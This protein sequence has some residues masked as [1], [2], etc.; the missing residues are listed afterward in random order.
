MEQFRTKPFVQKLLGMGDID[1]LIRKVEELNLDNNE[2]LINK[3]KHGEFT[4]RDMYEQFQNIMKMG[5][6][7]QLM[8]MIPGFSQD[9]M[10]KG[11]EQESSARLKRLL[12]IMDSM[13]DGELDNDNVKKTFERQP[14]RI[15]R[16]AQGAGVM[17]WEVHELLN[18]YTKFAQV[19]NT[20]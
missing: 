16:I 1:G 9:F 8:G 2:E 5:P 13:N 3:I 4:L 18:Q 19:G 11:H 15:P 7:G 10:T 14:T 6:F 17:E 12:T 20:N